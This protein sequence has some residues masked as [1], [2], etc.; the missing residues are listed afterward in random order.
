MRL[1]SLLRRRRL[2][3]GTNERTNE[4]RAVE[5]EWPSDGE[6]GVTRPD[7]KQPMSPV[8]GGAPERTLQISDGHTTAMRPRPRPRLTQDHGLI[9]VHRSETVPRGGFGG[10]MLPRTAEGERKVGGANEVIATRASKSAIPY[11]PDGWIK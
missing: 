8:F 6:Q 1:G 10:W 2:V 7:L 4:V 11:P 3:E 9:Q 5:K